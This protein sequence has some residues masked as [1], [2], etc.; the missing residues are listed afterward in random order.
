MR[1]AGAWPRPLAW[2]RLLRDAPPLAAALAAFAGV[3][4]AAP[5]RTA[6]DSVLLW[7]KG[8]PVYV[9]QMT[10]MTYSRGLRICKAAFTQA[11]G[12][13]PLP[14]P[15]TPPFDQTW[16]PP[17]PPA[18]WGLSLYLHGLQGVLDIYLRFQVL[19]A[20]EKEYHPDFSKYV[21]LGLVGRYIREDAMNRPKFPAAVVLRALAGNWT[22]EQFQRAAAAALHIKSWGDTRFWQVVKRNPG[23][24]AGTYEA[25]SPW[26]AV[27]RRAP[28]W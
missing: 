19:K 16:L 13:Q 2:P 3:A 26:D 5:Q 20:F 28:L 14:G 10:G 27:R 4:V 18:Q 12:L 6:P 17:R 25:F 1:S 11:G 9:D 21:H 22:G 8:K 7:F 15:T 24:F 23:F